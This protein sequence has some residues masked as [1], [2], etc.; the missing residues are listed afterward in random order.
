[1]ADELATDFSDIGLAYAEILKENQW[2]NQEQFHIMEVINNMLDEMPE[3]S[4]LWDENALI[5]TVKDKAGNVA[6][7]VKD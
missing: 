7:A 3:D 1:M 5:S 4:T 2:I 6:S